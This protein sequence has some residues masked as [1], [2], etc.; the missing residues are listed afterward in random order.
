MLYNPALG[1]SRSIN[2]WFD[3]AA[4]V[5]PAPYSFGN[6]GVNTLR[7]DGLVNFD[8]SL[9]RTFALSERFRLQFRG[10]LFNAFNHPN[11]GLPGSVLGNAD[12][13]LIDTAGPA[14]CVQ[15]GLRLTF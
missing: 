15:L 13:G 12:F 14:R 4:F 1:G 10:E 5:Q 3:T 2:A 8:F 7:G 6:Q 11:F 9:L